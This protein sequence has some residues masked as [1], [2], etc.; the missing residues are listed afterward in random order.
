MFHNLPA[1]GAK[2][3]FYEAIKYLSSKHDVNLYI[4]STSEEDFLNTKKLAKKVYTY[5]FNLE[6][7]YPGFLRRLHQDYKNFIVLKNIHKRIAKDIDSRGYDVVLTWADRFTESPYLLRYLKTPSVYSVMELL[8]IAYEDILAF[9]EDVGLHKK[10]YENFTRIIRKQID[11][12]NA[13]SATT[14]ISPSMF[15]IKQIKD[16]YKKDAVLVYGGVDS[17]TF[18][19]TKPSENKLLFM[20]GKT[21]QDDFPL[22]KN[23]VKNLKGRLELTQLDF[24]K[25][26]ARINNDRIVAEQY[27][28]AFATL[29]LDHAE[30]FGLKALES[31]SCETPVLAVNEGGY[32]E[33]VVDGK[34]GYLLPRNANIFSDKIIYLL[35]NKDLVKKLGKNGREYVKKNF[36]WKRH[37]E[38]LEKC[39]KRLLNENEN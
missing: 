7:K 9:R 4:L 19:K 23:I 20:G 16:T 39:L 37:G 34:N 33:S 38:E 1:G 21:D 25:G 13:Q 36:T 22:A 26:K 29:C 28:R 35:N 31:M 6:S 30:P 3:F 2:R 24:P 12:K 27:S 8:R 17:K 11:K 14:I 32:K 15:T 10:L 18:K 5:K